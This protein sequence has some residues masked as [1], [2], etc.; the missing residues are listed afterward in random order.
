M[1]FW[2]FTKGDQAVKGEGRTD[3]DALNEVRRKIDLGVPE[4]VVERSK[5]EIDLDSAAKKLVFA[6][7]IY[8]GYPINSRGPSGCILDALE[9]IA[10]HIRA[11]LSNG[12]DPAQVH[13][14]HWPND[15][16]PG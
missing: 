6:L 4:S 15:E 1:T 5:D 8:G 16:G 2:L 3:R 12:L 7:Y 9:V 10:P 14:L 11:D 13:E